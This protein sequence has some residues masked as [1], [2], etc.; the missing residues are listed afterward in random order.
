MNYRPKLVSGTEPAQVFDPWGGDPVKDWSQLTQR[1]DSILRKHGGSPL[2]WRG[3]VDA[4]WGLYSSLYRRLKSA[5]ASVTEDEMLREELA[6]LLRARREWRFDGMSA[7]EIL[8]HVQHY[9]GPTRLLDVTENP[10]IAAWFAVEQKWNQDGTAQ[11]DKDARVF[12]FYVGEYI[13]LSEAWTEA[14]PP[15]FKWNDSGTRRL[16]NWGTGLVRRVWRPPA[17]N[18]RISAQNGAFLMDGVP[19]AFPGG[20]QL[21]KG[22][23]RNAEKWSI[24]EIR[25]AS[26]VPLKLNR[27][28]VGRQG[29]AALPAFTFRIAASARE[30]IRERLERNYGYSTGSLYADLFGLAQNAAPHLPG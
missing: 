27:P 23:G 5:D 30:E 3:V 19:F 11:A 18:A 26:S 8:A 24:G 29:D 14:L 17:Y 10:L 16:N 4:E 22:P 7:L 15:W 28:S 9:G 25:D 1:I 20:N 21:P 6:L 13:D 2:V 12:C